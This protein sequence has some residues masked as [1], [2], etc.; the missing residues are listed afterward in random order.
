MNF[1][2]LFLISILAGT[3]L[4]AEARITADVSS[5]QVEGNTFRARGVKL[6]SKKNPIKAWV[7][8]LD[9]TN[10]ANVPVTV[11]GK[12][13][14]V[15]ITAPLVNE[16]TKM[17]LYVSGGN[18]PE[19]DPQSYFIVVINNPELDTATFSNVPTVTGSEGSTVGSVGPQG[20]QGG[21]GPRGVAGFIYDGDRD[22]DTLPD[23]DDSY[24][25]ALGLVKSVVRTVPLSS[26]EAGEINI[27]SANAVSIID[28][29]FETE[30]VIGLIKGTGATGQKVTF[31]VDDFFW[32]ALSEGSSLRKRAP[33][34]GSIVA[35]DFFDG[36]RR[37]FDA[38]RTIDV[39]RY[40]LMP[41]YSGMVLEFI[42][43][44]NQWR[45]INMPFYFG[46]GECGPFSA[47]VD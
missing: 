24:A 18:V 4:V 34:E 20:P 25:M 28:S 36:P 42:Y 37:I 10:P 45:L 16:D 21:T 19:S 47:C 15:K 14:A 33:V 3:F 13:N 9:G 8:N 1:K 32:L 17:N 35:P 38:T 31:I 39:E 27:D 46:F 29:N 30:D 5:V 26:Q 40:Q 44:G 6:S 41:V 7:T 11:N 2:K 43:D 22:I 12:K 23:Y